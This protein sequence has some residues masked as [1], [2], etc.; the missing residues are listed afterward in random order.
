METEERTTHDPRDRRAV[1]GEG[2]CLCGATRYSLHARPIAVVHCHCA[3]CRRATGAAFSTVAVYPRD[4]VS[5]LRGA[6]RRIEHAERL[7]LS[8][9][10]C[11]SPLG[12]LSSEAAAVLVINAGSHDHPEH[13]QPTCHVWDADRLPYVKI[14]DDLPRYSQMADR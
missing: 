12:V 10:T 13:L 9:P 1:L 11:G 4:A 2:G 14:Q 7:R 5:W 6:P 8:C 3:D